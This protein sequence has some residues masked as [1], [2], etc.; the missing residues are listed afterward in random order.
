[1]KTLLIE[2]SRFFRIAIEKSL[3]TAGHEHTGVVDGREALV[4]AHGSS[5]PLSST[6]AQTFRTEARVGAPESAS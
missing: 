1:M 3:V 4:V 5:P 6:E 2:D